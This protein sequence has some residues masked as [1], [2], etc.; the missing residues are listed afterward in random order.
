MLVSFIIVALNASKTLDSLLADLKAQS[1]DHKKIEFIF[2]D[3]LSTDNTKQII[4][5]FKKDQEAEFSSIII[6]DNPKKILPCGWNIALKQAKGDIILRVDAHSHLPSDFIEQNVKHIESGEHIT[7]GPRKSIIAKN[8]AWQQTLL[9]AETSMFGS[10]IAKYRNCDTTQ[11]VNTLAHAAYKRDVFEA[12]GGYDE[13]LARTEDNEI[14]YRMKQAG[15]HFLFSSDIKSFHHARSSLSKMLR[16]KYLNGYWIG[17]TMGISPHCFSIYHFIPLCF[18]LA[19]VVS[20]ILGFCVSWIFPA[21]VVGGYVLVNLLMT[22][23]SC[24]GNKFYLSYLCLPVLF[25]LLHCAYG[26]GTLWGLLKMPFWKHKPEN[27]ECLEIENTKRILKA[28]TNYPMTTD[29]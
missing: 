17:L 3:S 8:N 27:K 13:R 16:Q 4:E 21:V 15:F 22:L 1:Y 10:G 11:Y 26:I 19:L 9:L 6:L 14:H 28:N 7:G 25:F 18:V 24:L 12:V 29:E 5:N 2:V 23:F 20:I